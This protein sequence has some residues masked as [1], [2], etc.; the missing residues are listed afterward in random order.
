MTTFEPRPQDKVVILKRVPVFAA[1]TDEQLHLIADRTRLVEYK[2]G[3]HIYRQG[4]RAD[5]F[6]IVSSG[7]VRVFSQVDGQE[8]TFTIFHNGD[9]FGEI[10]LL[11]GETHSATVQ[12]LN[13]TLILQ[14]E[15]KDFDEVINR[16]PSLVLH[17]SRLLSKRLRTRELGAEFSESTI[18]AI[19]S[20]TRGVGRTAF[21]VSLAASLKRETGKEVVVVDFGGSG[22]SRGQLYGA[23]EP[24]GIVSSPEPGP[25]A[26][27]LFE[28]AVT[29]HPLGFSVLFANQVLSDVGRERQIAPLLSFLT[30]RFHYILLDLPVGTDAPILKALRQA[31]LVYLMTV[32]QRDAILRAKALVHQLHGSVGSL[33]HRVKVLVNMPDAPM[34][35]TEFADVV[36]QLEQP[37]AYTL[38]HIST[39]SGQLTWEE[40]AR[41]LE[42]RASPYAVTIRHM[43]REMSGLLVGLA[44]GSGA[45]LGLA[46]IGVLKVLEREQI[47]IDLIAGS[48]IGAFVGALWASGRSADEIEQIALQFKSPWMIRKLFLFDFGIPVLSV[49]IGLFAGMG[50]GWLAGAWTTGLLFGF[51]VC[52]AFGLVF[53]PLAGGP[54]QGARLMA[55]L[56]REFGDKTFETTRIPIKIVA[57]NPMAREEIIFESGRLADAVRAS[58]SIPGIFKPVV[59]MGK[60]CLDGGVINPVPISVLKRYGARHVIAVNVFATTAEQAANRQGVQQRRAER[61]AALASRSLPVRLLVRI[62]Q[63]LLRS[64]SPLIFDVIMRSMQSMEYQI[65]EIACREAD[66]T[67]R[68][69][70]PSANWLEFFHPEKFISRGEEVALQYLPELKRIAGVRSVDNAGTGQ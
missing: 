46:H 29:L 33:E 58:V 38:P 34:D 60:V 21:A 40:L 36:A 18:L 47:P 15:K 22:G 55:E 7:R 35:P 5:A 43:A 44:L 4:D 42:G 61:D 10:S 20:A 30:N 69:S 6:Y 54:I 17:L 8:K 14:L 24:K 50:V 53:G 3:E 25:P 1:C 11:T 70:V 31:D 13:D 45:A 49:V 57:A 64:V 41:L 52:I 32:P 16:I 68:P 66:L 2:K 26:E 62:R 59:R 28:A 51:M 67:L 48:S 63:E 37:I 56:E 23:A 19:Y 39:S 12:A 65:A 27:E 9:S